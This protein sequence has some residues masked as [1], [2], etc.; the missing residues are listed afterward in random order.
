MLPLGAGLV[1]CEEMVAVWRQTEMVVVGFGRG[2]QVPHPCLSSHA[3]TWII[4]RI[5]HRLIQIYS[6]NLSSETDGRE[7]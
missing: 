2:G 7:L 6:Q 4:S 5:G 1:C 3:D